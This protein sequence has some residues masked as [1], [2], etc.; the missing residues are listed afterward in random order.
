MSQASESEF[1]PFTCNNPPPKKKKRTKQTNLQQKQ[2]NQQ[3]QH[4]MHVLKNGLADN[5]WD[6]LST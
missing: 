4:S 3:Q 2:K 5:L 6:I 1:Y